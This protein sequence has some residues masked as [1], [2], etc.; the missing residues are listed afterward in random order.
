MQAVGYREVVQH[1]RGERDLPA[2]VELVRTRTRFA[3][4]RTPG[5][6]A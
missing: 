6:A 5:S 2:T 4:R 1:L 3:R